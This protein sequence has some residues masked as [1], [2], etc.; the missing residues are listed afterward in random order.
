M[1]ITDYPYAPYGHG[2]IGGHMSTAK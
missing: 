2:L 1:S